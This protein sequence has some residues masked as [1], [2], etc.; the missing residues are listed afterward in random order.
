MEVP[1]LGVESE[2]QLPAYTRATATPDPAAS[3]TYTTAHGNAGYLTHWERPLIKPATS[4]FLVRFVNHWATMG[5]PS[6]LILNREIYLW[7][8]PGV[9]FE[10][11]VFREN[12]CVF[13]YECL[14]M[15]FYVYLCVCITYVHTLCH[16]YG[17]MYTCMC[18]YVL[19]YICMHIYVCVYVYVCLADA[20][21]TTMRGHF[22]FLV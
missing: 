4:W 17:L 2:L 19:N 20:G 9:W 15:C 11:N 16:I 5:T 18:V 22:K 13:M 21:G 12:L 14:C 1:R 7:K 3:A 6:S 10:K 8:F